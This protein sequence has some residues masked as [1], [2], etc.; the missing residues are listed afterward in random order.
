MGQ[1]VGDGG[2]VSRTGA[3]DGVGQQV[4][5]IIPQSGEGVLRG[6]A[7][8]IGV[9]FDKVGDLGVGVVEGGVGGV[10]DGVGHIA[11]HFTDEGGIEAIA[12]EDGLGQARLADLE[13]GDAGLV[14]DGRDE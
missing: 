3:A 4:H 12:G 7:V 9:G 1:G 11:G 14:G 13:G 2:R 5:H 6:A 10:V 8:L